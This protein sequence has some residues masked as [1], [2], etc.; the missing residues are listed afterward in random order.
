[1]ERLE[2]S[3]WLV[4]EAQ[5]ALTHPPFSGTTES[6]GNTCA[7][8]NDRRNDTYRSPLPL[9]AATTFQEFFKSTRP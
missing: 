3:D 1:M 5:L 9:V 2:S 7:L 6:I 8:I 4:P